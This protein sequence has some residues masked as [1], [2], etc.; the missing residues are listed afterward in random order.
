MKRRA[1]WLRTPFFVLVYSTFFSFSHSDGIVISCFLLIFPPLTTLWFKASHFPKRT[2]NSKTTTPVFRGDI[3][4]FKLRLRLASGY[5]GCSLAHSLF[6]PRKPNDA[7]SVIEYL[8]V[9]FD[10]KARRQNCWARGEEVSRKG[11]L[12]NISLFTRLG[13]FCAKAF[14]QLHCEGKENK[15]QMKLSR[16]AKDT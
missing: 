8:N 10:G 5:R 7:V 11:M 12:M 6:L 1:L 2:Q 3:F 9:C 15:R 16:L 14:A 4:Q 13:F